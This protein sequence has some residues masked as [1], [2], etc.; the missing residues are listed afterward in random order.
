M[1]ANNLR[2]FVYSIINEA[3]GWWED[4]PKDDIYKPKVGDRVRVSGT[5]LRYYK[6]AQSIQKVQK[7]YSVDVEIIRLGGHHAGTPGF[8]TP[9]ND[10]WYCRPL[11]K[12]Q[13]VKAEYILNW[14]LRPSETENDGPGPF[15]FSIRTDGF[16]GFSVQDAEVELLP[17]NE[18]KGWWDE[19]PPECNDFESRVERLV[20]G[21]KILAVGF[22]EVSKTDVSIE[23]TVSKKASRSDKYAPVQWRLKNA[24]NDTFFLGCVLPTDLSWSSKETYW[25]LNGPDEEPK[26]YSPTIT[27][28]SSISSPV[29]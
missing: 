20:N 18:A 14:T 5:E 15:S 21:V 4:E 26:I 7:S 27:V 2:S 8:N 29:S 16:T 17:V 23:L 12:K 24:S 10:F 13:I 22:D 6:P 1:S 9:G 3:K 25:T 11:N 19:Y 28:I